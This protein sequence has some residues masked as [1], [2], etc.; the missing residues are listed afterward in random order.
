MELAFLPGEPI[1]EGYQLGG[2]S[3]RNS[4]GR[5]PTGPGNLHCNCLV[6]LAQSEHGSP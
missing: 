4:G 5:F 1:G 3:S 2:Y 6:Y